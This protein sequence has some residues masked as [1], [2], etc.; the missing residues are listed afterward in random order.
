MGFHNSK[1]TATIAL[2]LM[3][4]AVIASG[5]QKQSTLPDG[6]GKDGLTKVCSSCH[7]LEVVTSARRTKNGWQ[8]TIDDMIA[9]GAEGS[10][11]NMEAVL[12]YLTT[13]FGR[14]NVNAASAQELEKSLDLL[15][16]EAQAIV[17]YRERNG[18]IKDLDELKKVPGVIADRLQAKQAMIAFRP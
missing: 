16:K 5:Q 14:V 3:A 11:E 10:D 9:R 1:P 2:Y 18:K 13:Y 8:L 15:A 7:E 4:Y 6:P 12:S 17:A